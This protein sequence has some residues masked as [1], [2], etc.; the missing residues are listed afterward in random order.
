MGHKGERTK[1]K[2]CYLWPR[3]NKENVN[4][5]KFYYKNIEL[6]IV[7]NFKYLGILF[8][9]NGK[10][11]QARKAVLSQSTRAMFMVLSKISKLCLPIDIALDLCDHMISPVL[12]YGCEIWGYEKCTML[13]RLHL[14][15]C[16]YL[17]GL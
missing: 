17:L 4:I 6:E 3:K 14:K 16:K 15:F 11:L 12:T 10:F 13:E 1:N 8:S 2:N 7:D 5:V 9:K